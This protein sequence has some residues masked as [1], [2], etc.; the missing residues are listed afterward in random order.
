VFDAS[1][2]IFR[3]PHRPH[4]ASPRSLPRSSNAIGAAASHLCKTAAD[5]KPERSAHRINCPQTE[6][7][8]RT[9][10]VA[11][12]VRTGSDIDV[13]HVTLEKF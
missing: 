10:T 8:K 13:Q 1:P 7:I 9:Q 11:A 3:I 5:F 6:R 4:R 12:F 2:A